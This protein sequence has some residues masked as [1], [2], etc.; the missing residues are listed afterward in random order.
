[1]SIMKVILLQDVEKLGKAGEVKD[2][3]SGYGFNFL[4]PN[5]LAEFATPAVIKTAEK[6]VS[7][8]KQDNEA[9]VKALKE[10]ALALSDRKVTISTKA[11]K[12]KLFGSIGKEEI[13]LALE[14]SGV[15]IDAR[16]IV[17][18]KGLKEVGVFPVE[19]NFG[20]GVKA[21]FEVTIKAE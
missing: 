10:T 4:L 2:V 3:R 20:N 6:I 16:H 14:A 15:K 19:A 1:M 11:E 8:R 5:G 12:G 17:L 13:A 18:E 9:I 7:R 21:S